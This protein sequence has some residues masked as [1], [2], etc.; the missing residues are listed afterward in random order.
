MTSSHSSLPSR[1]HSIGDLLWQRGIATFMITW[2]ATPYRL[3]TEL[4]AIPGLPVNDPES[5]H[6][7]PERQLRSSSPRRS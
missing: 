4:N 6:R 7:Y 2:P 5:E 3:S 1:C